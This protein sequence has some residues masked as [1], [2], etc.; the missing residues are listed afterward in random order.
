[1]TNPLLINAEEPLLPKAQPKSVYDKGFEY[2][3]EKRRLAS[4]HGALWLLNYQLAQLEQLRYSA[5]FGLFWTCT[6][7]FAVGAGLAGY[8]VM[9]IGLNNIAHD[10]NWLLLSI[11]IIA[12]AFSGLLNF[13]LGRKEPTEMIFDQMKGEDEEELSTFRKRLAATLAFLYSA[14]LTGLCAYGMWLFFD[15]TMDTTASWVD[16]VK[17]LLTSMLGTIFFI[18]EFS[19][20]NKFNKKW[21]KFTPSEHLAHLYR[22][23][24]GDWRYIAGYVACLSCVLV[25][26]IFTSLATADVV[27]SIM[28]FELA[29][30]LL[31]LLS[32]TGI[33][34]YAEKAYTQVTNLYNRHHGDPEPEKHQSL[35]VRLTRTMNALGNA[36]PAFLGGMAVDGAGLGVFTAICGFVTSFLSGADGKQEGYDAVIEKE[37]IATKA[38]IKTF[39][40]ADKKNSIKPEP[41]LI[42]QHCISVPITQSS[43]LFTPF[44]RKRVTQELELGIIQGT[45]HALSL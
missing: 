41:E 40:S 31:T 7:A 13:W 34:F 29:V 38:D 2:F 20:C 27:S 42:N 35:W 32:L 1:M 8:F 9:T 44:Y 12:G 21:L 39:A 14:L 45:K 37:I 11:P 16:P 25:G 17:I 24:K 19:I 22:D 23:V 3:A 18:P 10:W 6:Y 43:I 30:A 26:A 4:E 36:V 5:R 33:S 15:A 28:P